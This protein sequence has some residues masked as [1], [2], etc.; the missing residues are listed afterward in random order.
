MFVGQG[1]NHPCSADAMVAR[2]I[3]AYNTSRT[4]MECIIAALRPFKYGMLWR[5]QRS[6]VDAS[7]RHGPRMTRLRRLLPDALATLLDR[8]RI[9]C[10]AKC[11]SM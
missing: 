9:A 11:E 8:R 2:L 3:E 5:R 4:G 10:A 6:E 1:V 7:M